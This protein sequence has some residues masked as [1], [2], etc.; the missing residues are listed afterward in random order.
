MPKAPGLSWTCSRLGDRRES[1][2]D[3]SAGQR[4]RAALGKPVAKGTIETIDHPHHIPHHFILQE[5][6]GAD[7]LPRICQ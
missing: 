2:G 6:A 4:A 3:H 5:P 7:R 1:K